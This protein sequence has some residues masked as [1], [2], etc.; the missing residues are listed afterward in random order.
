MVS[1]KKP[2]RKYLTLLAQTSPGNML[3]LG[4][5]RELEGCLAEALW[6]LSE[7]VWGSL[8]IFIECPSSTFFL[9]PLARILETY[10]LVQI[11]VPPFSSC[12]TLDKLLIYYVSESSVKWA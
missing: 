9:R 2:A 8:E 12:V 3:E 1:W 4:C 7:I 10:Y 11:L 6:I 5:P